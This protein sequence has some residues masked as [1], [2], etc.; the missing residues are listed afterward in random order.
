MRA[1]QEQMHISLFG[2]AVHLPGIDCLHGAAQV[3]CSCRPNRDPKIDPLN[4]GSS[5]VQWQP[6]KLVLYDKQPNLFP[7]NTEPTNTLG[8]L[9]YLDL[10]NTLGQCLGTLA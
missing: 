9:N 6:K 4:S 8:S 10:E 7:I 5:T 2:E 1:L 3:C